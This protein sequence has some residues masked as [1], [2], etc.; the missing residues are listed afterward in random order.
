MAVYTVKAVSESLGISPSTLRAWEMRYGAVKPVRTESNQ[1]VYTAPQLE[2]LQLLVKLVNKGHRI[3]AIAKLPPKKLYNLIGDSRPESVQH[4]EGLQSILDCLFAF[5]LNGLAAHLE[6]ARLSNGVREFVLDIISPLMREVGSLVAANKIS[7]AQEH[8]LSAL[9]RNQLGQIMY[10]LAG[11][12]VRSKKDEASF[13]F[14]TPNGDWHEFGI[15]MAAVL[16]AHHG[17]KL[18]YLGANLPAE[19]LILAARA[20]KP[21]V[22]VLGSTAGTQT[23]EN[24][25]EE[26]LKYLGKYLNPEIEVWIGGSSRIPHLRAVFGKRKYLVLSDLNDFE[27]RLVS[28]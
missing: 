28:R 13:L 19:S 16:C 1:R 14:T 3:A 27:D 10:G 8:A 11:N 5:D 26:Y 24:S 12:K 22:V 15:L 9:V 18:S 4:K 20:L 21:D 7:V 2:Y 17:R 25:L 23:G 6:L